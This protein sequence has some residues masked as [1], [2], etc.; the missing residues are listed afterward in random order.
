MRSKS[1]PSRHDDLFRE[2]LDAMINMRHPLVRL[3]AVIDWQGFDD[4]FGTLYSPIG[5]PGVVTRLMVGLHYLKH[6]G[7][8]SDELVVERWL[9][10]PYWQYFCGLEYFSHELPIDP[11]SMTR[12]R[13]R[14]GP[15]AM[16]ALLK[17]T[18]VAALDTDTIKPS[19]LERV[20]V[21]T[22]V[23]PKAIAHPTDARLYHKALQ[24]LV[25]KA[26]KFGVELRQSHTRLAK[27]AA[28]KV[29]R[30]AHARQFKRMRRELKRLKTYLGRVFR[31]VSR[32][33]ADNPQL[34][35]RF[36][37]L[38]GRIERLLAQQ[39]KDTGKLYALHAPEVVCIAK[40]K[41][42]K[43]YE[44]G[45]K[46]GIAVT[47]REGLFLAA[48]AFNGNPF[49]GHTL[50][51][52]LNQAETI[53]DTAIQRVYVDRGY[54]GHDYAGRA[55]VMIAGQ[56]R[57]LTPTMR[58]ELKRRSAIEPMIGHAK[59]DGRLGRNHLLGSNGDKINA[60]LAAAGLNLRL[61]LNRLNRFLRLFLGLGTMVSLRQLARAALA[62]ARHSE[63]AFTNIEALFKQPAKSAA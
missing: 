14:I 48:C 21:D 61:I 12:W 17:A 59:N 55:R 26:R 27:R 6:T 1:S 28:L 46:V 52:T 22:T 15:E 10:N 47:N 35:Q 50:T 11:S 43:R 16:E 9:E 41:A 53:T 45:A 2:R 39:P 32:K 36:A 62:K 20:T 25:K 44:F 58:R 31:D 60:L 18:V 30:Y 37:R 3:A 13:Q 57:G 42:H 24:L 4:E 63:L 23:Q 56:K 29:G 40:G 34:Q 33:I 38:L 19:S 8:L 49:D 5:R 51:S 7:N 54:R